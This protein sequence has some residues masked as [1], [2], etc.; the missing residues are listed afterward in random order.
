MQFKRGQV[1]IPNPFSICENC[2]KACVLSN[3]WGGKPKDYVVGCVFLLYL[4][5][6]SGYEARYQVLGK[7]CVFGMGE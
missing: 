5:Y 7:A 4:Q 1:G 2:S 3:L 6:V